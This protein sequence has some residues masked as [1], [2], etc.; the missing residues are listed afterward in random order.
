MNWRFDKWHALGVGLIVLALAM[1]VQGLWIQH[2]RQ[3]DQDCQTTYNKDVS[4]VIAQRSGWADEDRAALNTMI[5]AVVND[6]LSEDK[7]QEAVLNYVTVS[8]ENDA[9]RKA[10]PLPEYH[11]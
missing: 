3:I 7:Q 10:N 9:N 4:A 8:Q 1:V 11:C 5:Y 2:L 6:K